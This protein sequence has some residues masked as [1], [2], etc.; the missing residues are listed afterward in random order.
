M[1]RSVRQYRADQT[2]AARAYWPPGRESRPAQVS[3]R[4]DGLGAEPRG[5]RTRPGGERS[6][7]DVMSLSRVKGR[8]QIRLTVA[9][10]TARS[11]WQRLSSRPRP[12]PRIPSGMVFVGLARSAP[13]WCP[14]RCARVPRE[15]EV[16]EVRTRTMQQTRMGPDKPAPL[17]GVKPEITRGRSCPR[18]CSARSLRLC[19][20]PP[21]LTTCTNAR[22]PNGRR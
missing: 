12:G 2:R 19:T 21:I 10:M 8:S 11:L 1:C 16:S 3:P 22:R 18:T 5:T 17:R 15:Q 4:A 6:V 9:W 14:C 13:R 20:R 7:V